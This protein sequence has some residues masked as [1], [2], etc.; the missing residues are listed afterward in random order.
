M[1]KTFRLAAIAAV[2]S[3]ALVACKNNKQVEEEIDTVAIEEIAD[4]AIVE[5]NV[6][7]VVAVAA[8][9]AKAAATTATK[10]VS[11]PAPKAKEKEIKVDQAPAEEVATKNTTMKDLG[12]SQQVQSNRRKR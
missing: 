7:T 2:A 9:E 12:N 5:E 3:L 10:K 8:T 6:D 4:E 1:K 11:A